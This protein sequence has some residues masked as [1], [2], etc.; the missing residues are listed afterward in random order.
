MICLKCP[1]EAIK[2]CR[3]CYG[4]SCP[5]ATCSCGPTVLRDGS[6]PQ[7]ADNDALRQVCLKCGFRK[8]EYHAL[9]CAFCFPEAM[10]FETSWMLD[11]K[12]GTVTTPIPPIRQDQPYFKPFPPIVEFSQSPEPPAFIERVEDFE[13]E[14]EKIVHPETPVQLS[15]LGGVA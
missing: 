4:Y 5:C 14:S 7:F 12:E 11:L 10:V 13:Q 8:M 6:K 3:E 1:T 15:L 9:S 2:F